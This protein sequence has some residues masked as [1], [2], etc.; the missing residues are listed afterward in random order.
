MSRGL[1][2][3]PRTDTPIIYKYFEVPDISASP[4]ACHTAVQLF[5]Q[6]S[7]CFQDEPKPRPPI[8]CRTWYSGLLIPVPDTSIA[9]AHRHQ[10][11]GLSDAPLAKRWRKHCGFGRVARNAANGCYATKERVAQEGGLAADNS[12]GGC[13]RLRCLPSCRHFVCSLGGTCMDCTSK[14]HKLVETFFEKRRRLIT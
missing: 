9:Q 6:H 12:G 13:S 14:K 10:A 3:A 11:A 2:S 5:V 1:R 8:S 4:H 7:S